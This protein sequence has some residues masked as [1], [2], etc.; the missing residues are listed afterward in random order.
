MKLQRNGNIYWVYFT[1]NGEFWRKSTCTSDRR[2]AQSEAEAIVRQAKAG[3]IRRTYDP[4]ERSARIGETQKRSLENPK[5]QKAHKAPWTKK[6]RKSW[7][8]KKKKEMK[9]PKVR[10]RISAGTTAAFDKE[11]AAL[12][13]KGLGKDAFHRL[14]S[15]RGK[16]TWSRDDYRTKQTAERRRRGRTRKFRQQMRAQTKK[17]HGTKKYQEAVAEGRLK[18]S[19]ARL[20]E[21]GY[22]IAAP[23]EPRTLPE[24]RTR[25]R[26]ERDRI[27]EVRIGSSVERLLENGPRS[28]K[29][30]IAARQAVF[31]EELRRAEAMK[32]EGIEYDTIAQYHKRYVRQQKS[33]NRPQSGTN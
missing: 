23:G 7:G 13:Q 25:K 26:K 8:R 6:R 15:E 20:R 4:A 3:E 10:L 5:T 9:D 30:I 28:K 29:S 32:E 19:V 22:T 24:P 1:L 12:V 16:T 14:R 21:K 31:S 33:Q 11:R 27:S 18:S 17:L 2:R